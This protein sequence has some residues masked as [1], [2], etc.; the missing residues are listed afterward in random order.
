MFSWE[1]VVDYIEWG[2]DGGVTIWL[3]DLV[4]DDVFA[5]IGFTEVTRRAHA[6]QFR[7]LLLSYGFH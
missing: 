4:E 5:E 1:F 7:A 2:S 6:S 3:C